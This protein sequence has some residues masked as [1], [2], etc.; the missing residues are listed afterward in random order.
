[1]KRTISL[2]L[3][4]FLVISSVVILAGCG[5]VSSEQ[6]WNKALDTLKNAKS[7]TIKFKET[8]APSAI[9]VDLK[10]EYKLSYN[11]TKGVLYY[12]FKHEKYNWLGGADYASYEDRYYVVKGSDVNYYFR[13]YHSS[14]SDDKQWKLSIEHFDSHEEAIAALYEEF[15][16]FFPTE[17]NKID[18]N[19]YPNGYGSNKVERH[20]SDDYYDYTYQLKFSS[21]K[22]VKVYDKRQPKEGVG[23]TTLKSTM[24]ISYVATIS[25]PKGISDA[26]E[27]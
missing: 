11:R 14:S 22:L 24:K 9:H 7:V 2:F 8:D 23:G 6:D 16:Y 15:L 13:E 18:F 10:T 20:E 4:A 3:V 5:G 17:L 26:I 21:G 27:V 12:S 1:M 19:S 25:A